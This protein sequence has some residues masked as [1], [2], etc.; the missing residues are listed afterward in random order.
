MQRKIAIVATKIALKDH[1]DLAVQLVAAEEKMK[2]KKW[3]RM[4][5]KIPGVCRL[6]TW[7]AKMLKKDL[8]EVQDLMFAIKK[9]EKKNPKSPALKKLYIKAIM[10]VEHAGQSPSEMNLLNQ[11]LLYRRLKKAGGLKNY[12]K[13]A[14]I[15]EK[16]KRFAK[17]GPFVAACKQLK[18]EGKIK[19]KKK[20]K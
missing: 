18:E 7:N 6:I 4:I 17:T 13:A 2:I 11:A 9:L 12:I 8:E 16:A 19:S 5:A 3:H 14:K 1:S 15:V 10:I 20:K